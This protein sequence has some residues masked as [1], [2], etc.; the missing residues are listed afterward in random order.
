MFAD[1]FRA[2]A[3]GVPTSVRGAGPRVADDSGP[4]LGLA[5]PGEG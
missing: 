2:Y 1:N 3:D 4:G 5:G